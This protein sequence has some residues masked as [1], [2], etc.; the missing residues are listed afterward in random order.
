MPNLLRTTAPLLALLACGPDLPDGW[1][2]AQRVTSLTQTECLTGSPYE[3]YDERVE[4]DLSVSPLQVA[5]REA[6]FRCAQDVAG[7]YRLAGTG[8]DV[9]VQPIDMNPRA[10]A[11]CDCLYDIDIALRLEV[12]LAPERVTVYRRSDNL[13]APNE[14]V[15]IGSVERD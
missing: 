8:V 4:G 11:G 3:G 5:L 12:D 7:F 1:S 6:R 15:L 10:V 9:L 2:D 14:P 13:S